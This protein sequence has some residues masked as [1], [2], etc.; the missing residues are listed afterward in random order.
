MSR[1]RI[2][3]INV[4][5]KLIAIPGRMPV[6]RIKGAKYI[7][8]FF[9]EFYPK[10][11]KFAE[12]IEDGLYE[13]Y[14]VTYMCLQVAAYMGFKEIYLLGVDHSYSTEMDKN[15]S[16]IRKPD[17]KDHF[18]ENDKVTNIPQLYKS[19]LAYEMAKKSAEKLGIKI[20]NVTR[21]GALEIFER[22][23]L[24]DVL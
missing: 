6:I 11:P 7:R 9:K 23:K 21:G 20:Y 3:N 1:E 17:I 16:L 4:K 12:N 24:E 2:E 18:S 10:L 22:R 14:T 8:L 15:G 5:N 13:G 19:T